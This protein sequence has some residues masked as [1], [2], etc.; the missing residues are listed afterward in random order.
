M[1]QSRAC[2]QCPY[3]HH[4]SSPNLLSEVCTYLGAAIIVPATFLLNCLH[5][6][7]NKEAVMRGTLLKSFI[8]NSTADQTSPSTDM[9][10][11]WSVCLS[12][13]VFLG[14][15][16]SSQAI[17]GAV[18]DTDF[19]HLLPNI[20]NPWSPNEIILSYHLMLSAAVDTSLLNNLWSTSSVNHILKWQCT[21]SES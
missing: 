12:R 16:A 17:N 8:C 9:K 13:Q 20:S 2:T 10:L 18:I 15:P 14:L 1:K 11:N 7:T 21:F 3:S 19:T 6:I 4:S 5:K